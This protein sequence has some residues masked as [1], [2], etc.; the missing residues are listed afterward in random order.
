MYKHGSGYYLLNG[1]WHKLHKDKPAPK[2]VPIAAHKHAAGQ[3]T[4]AKHFTDEQWAQLQ[5]PAENVNA[6]SYNKQLAAVKEMAEAGDV[7]GLL[8]LGIGTNTYG[9]KLAT[10]INHLLGLY[11]SEHKVSAGQKAGTHAAVQAPADAAP[12]AADEPKTTDG[13]QEPGADAPLAQHVKDTLDEKAADGDV[14][15]LQ[16]VAKNNPEHPQIVAY[17]EKLLAGLAPTGPSIAELQAAGHL[18]VA[19]PE[20]A[21]TATA[22]AGHPKLDMIPWDAQLLPDSNVNAKSHNGQVA[23]IKAMAYA[24]D[25]AGLQAFID[26]KAGAKQNYA[27]K[28]HLLAQTAL[29]GLN[30]GGAA[31]AAVA[32]APAVSMEGKPAYDAVAIAVKKGTK[33]I[34]AAEQWLAA[35]P[36]GHFEL[37]EAL[38]SLGHDDVAADM[39]LPAPGMEDDEPEP[40]PATPALTDAQKEGLVGWMKAGKPTTNKPGSWSALWKQLSSEQKAEVKAMHDAPEPSPNV[41]TADTPL[42]RKQLAALES[43]SLAELKA[44]DN[45]P[46]LPE[47]V[48]AWIDKKIPAM[49]QAAAPKTTAV[50]AAVF[51]NTTG[52]SSKFWSVSVHGKTMKTVYGKIGTKGQ[53]TTKEFTSV[54]SAQAA[55]KKLL[56]EKQAKGYEYAGTMKAVHDAPAGAAAAD[57]GPKDGDTKQGADGML[58]FKD[59]HWHKQDSGASKPAP[60][61]GGIPPMDGWVQTGGQGGSN[62]GGKFRDPSGQEWYCK[63]PDDADT[64]KSEVLAAKLYAMA[65]LS[66]QDAMLV[67]KGGKVGIASKWVNIS[68]AGS[69]AALAKVPGALDGFAVDAWLGN[70]DVVGLSLDNLQIGPDGKAH[71]VDAGGSLEYRAQGAKKPFGTKV[72]EIDTLRD[73]VKNP[74]SAAVFGGM[75]DADISA[76]VAK[77]AAISDVSIRAMVNEFGPGTAADKAKLAETLIARKQDLIKRYPKAVKAKKKPVFKPEKI[78]APPSFLNWGGSGKSGP[79]SKEFL[80]QA[81]E[82]AVQAIFAAAKTGN[83][84]AVKS[85]KAKV[86]NKETGAVIGEKPVLEH[87]SQ[88][89]KGYAQQAIN[90]IEYQ[91]NPPKRFRFDGGHPLHSLNKAYP[92]HSG[93]PSSAAAQKLGKFIVLGEPGTIKLEDVGLPAKIKHP[94]GGGSMTQSTYSPAAQAAVAKMPKTQL[95]AV[96]SYTG[97]SYHEMNGSLWSG[98]PS[99]AAKAAAEA[100]KTLGHDIVPGTVLSRKLSLH[101]ADLDALLKA[102]GKVLEEP[103]IMSTSIRPSSW[104]GNVHL[105]LHIGPGVKGLWVGPGSK[106]GGGA[107]SKHG[108]EDEMILPPNTRMLIISAKQ[109]TGKDEDGFGT[110]G[111]H[112]IEAVVLPTQ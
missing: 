4:P 28:Q 8:G 91:L 24:G 81:N 19:E 32:P 50:D 37:S 11:G 95:Q 107:V 87:P 16:N 54:A 67:T 3:Y 92:A 23:K 94:E 51:H 6:G 110:H 106:P 47:N 34:D 55:A 85:L 90:E 25:A 80:N 30:E 71:R 59:G 82:D 83:L 101:G 41:I 56:N 36:G 26:K 42:G 48:Q 22:A 39:D 10:V 103:A 44:I 61:A 112:I 96:Q 18:P 93:A 17:A 79:S 53:S 58:V 13:L 84:D 46:G 12:A 1:R 15:F 7:T 104:S 2:G 100:L 70:W 77:V 38:A 63:F 14:E 45:S 88:H 98:N 108:G 21:A 64:A 27:K 105:K 75:K 35:N 69:A 62:P 72:E 86:Y 76:S 29:A 57:N 65:G 89:V 40:E 33:P 73:A 111:G 20:A 78:S 102:K 9:K 109:A 99:G 5:L 66:G 68:K 60:T 74:Q 52:G 97:S 49:E 43:L 31:P